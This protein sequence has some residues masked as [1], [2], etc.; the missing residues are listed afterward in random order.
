MNFR[1]IF[2]ICLLSLPFV[3]L[4]SAQD[5]APAQA[6]MRTS[7]SARPVL[8]AKPV[9]IADAGKL[10]HNGKLS[11]SIYIST[12]D[13]EMDWWFKIPPNSVP[14]IADTTKVF[15]QQSFN[16]F[17]FAD[18]VS[19]I[20]GKFSLR[21]WITLIKPDGE[22]VS[23]VDNAEFSGAKPARDTILSLPDIAT[24][25]FDETYPDKKYTFELRLRDVFAK[26]ESLAQ[27][28][29]WLYS[30]LSPNPFV[31]KGDVRSIQRNFFA[32]PSP[33][34]L[35]AIYFSRDFS[36]EQK[37]APNSL[38]FSHIG[39]LRAAFARNAFLIP[40]IRAEFE[41]ST[42]EN[43]AKIIFLLEILGEKNLPESSLKKNEKAYLNRLKEVLSIPNPYAH[44]EPVLA[45]AQIDMLWGEFYANGTYK[46]FRRILDILALTEEA[47]FSDVM[48]AKKKR[49]ESEQEWRKLMLG[50]ASRA[51]LST[52]ASNSGKIELV[53]K[54]AQWA[55]QNGDVP[56]KS[57]GLLIE[58]NPSKNIK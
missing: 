42:P 48:I 50:I 5:T 1:E 57:R 54:Y 9:N 25:R 3:S 21:Y 35:Y 39:F 47:T 8:E 15:Y 41:N 33:E 14:H 11:P 23:I 34:N 44:W 6:T 28:S 58:E 51:A 43:R 55:I 49:P 32:E 2:L 10:V 31:G 53:K 40:Y 22:R 37:G 45:G 12:Q 30:W 17:A 24:I 36:L 29:V 7:R 52:I 16:V 26:T 18:N 4:E 56:E 13:S 20:D 38:N 27:T 46:P 19:T